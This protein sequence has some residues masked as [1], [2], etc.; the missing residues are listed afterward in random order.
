MF[1][2]LIRKELFLGYT[3]E[4]PGRFFFFGSRHLEAQGL[5]EL[6][7]K[8]RFCFLKQVHGRKVIEANPA[9]VA[10]ADAQFT[11]TP[12]LALVVQTA[13]CIPLL[14]GSER[15]VCAVHAGWKGVAQNIVSS[16]ASQLPDFSQAAIGPHIS[17]T[18]FAVGLEVAESLRQSDPMGL[19]RLTQPHPNPA[20]VFFD[21]RALLK[22]QLSASFG[23]GVQTFECCDDTMTVELFHSFRR[24]GVRAGRQCSFVVINP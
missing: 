9:L 21:L 1:K 19:A 23:V 6:F 12:G 22:A 7:P 20:K 13:D 16:V 14:L 3:L 11:T 8:Y 5:S 2:S 15:S 18:S 4:L 24:D 17:A 10:E